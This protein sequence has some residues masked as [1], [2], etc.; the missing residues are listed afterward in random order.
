MLTLKQKV[1]AHLEEG[2][3]YAKGLFDGLGESSDFNNLQAYC[4]FVGYPRSGHT[5]IGSLLDAH[6]DM[7]IAHELD[8]LK[9]LPLIVNKNQLYSMLLERSRWFCR[10]GRQWTGYSYE[11]PGQW[12]GKFRKLQVI[13]DKK[14]GMSTLR[15]RENP[16]LIYKLQ[17]IVGIPVKFIHVVRNPYDNITTI[18]NK[19]SNLYGL[20]ESIVYYFTHCETI[21]DL[22][23]CIS[24]KDIYEVALELFIEDPKRYLGEMCIFLGVDVDEEYLDACAKLIFSSPK[25]TRD[26]VN[27]TSE[28]ENNVKQRIQDFEFL[29]I[30]N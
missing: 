16:D 18:L 24:E 20:S 14:G 3:L 28:D 12:Q 22:K 21:V 30:Y 17:K 27:W 10:I 29:S 1:A 9:Y 25:R 23:S 5:L 11:V 8:A 26:R 7:V 13:G 2:R 6:P 15:L 19:T 4:M